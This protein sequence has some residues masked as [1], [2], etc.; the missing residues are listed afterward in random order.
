MLA[1]MMLNIS[2]TPS[3]ILLLDEY[4]KSHLAV[5]LVCVLATTKTKGLL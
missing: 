5:L 2:L 1:M 3:K 4:L